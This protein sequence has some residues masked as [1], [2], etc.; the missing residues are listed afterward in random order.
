M[1]SMEHE[2]HERYLIF[3][4]VCRISTYIVHCDPT[5]GNGGPYILDRDWM[6]APEHEFNIEQKL[7]I[8]LFEH[9]PVE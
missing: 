1:D 9:Q 3:V 7:L 5:I 6:V 8:L 4:E 2:G